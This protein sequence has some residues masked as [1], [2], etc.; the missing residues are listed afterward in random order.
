M[1]T[2]AR[3]DLI[4]WLYA[5]SDNQRKQISVLKGAMLLEENNKK[6][7]CLRYIQVLQ[8]SSHL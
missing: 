5:I 3:S 4:G 2:I 6:E 8:G 7:Q 1:Q